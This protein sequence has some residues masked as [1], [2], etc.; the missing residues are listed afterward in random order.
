MVM[1]PNVPFDTMTTS[2][3]AFVTITPA[4]FD[5]VSATI[6]ALEAVTRNVFPCAFSVHVSAFID[7][8]IMVLN[9]PLF[10][11]LAFSASTVRF[12]LLW[13]PA[14]MVRLTALS[15][16]IVMSVSAAFA[17]AASSSACVPTVAEADTGFCVPVSVPG[18]CPWFAAMTLTRHFKVFV[19]FVLRADVFRLSLIVALPVLL[20]FNNT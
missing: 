11:T 5:A 3:S 10:V 16:R 12:T 8:R 13:L 20:P 2:A 6:L 18:F 4:I 14:G 15:V 9:T 19:F 7:A 1:P 17:S